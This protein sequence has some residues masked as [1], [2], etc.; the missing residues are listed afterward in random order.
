MTIHR[1]FA[2]R[3]TNMAGCNVFMHIKA[4]VSVGHLLG[5]EAKYCIQRTKLFTKISEKIFKTVNQVLVVRQGQSFGL[6]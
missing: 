3:L 2:G 1:L 6:E 5:F 4:P